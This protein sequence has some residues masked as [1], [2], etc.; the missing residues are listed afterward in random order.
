MNKQ[1]VLDSRDLCDIDL[2]LNGS[3]D[4]VNS[5]MG[6]ADYHSVLTDMR[7]TNGKVFPLPITLSTSMDIVIGET[8]TLVDK[9]NYPI[10][11]IKL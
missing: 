5:Y 6:E 1:L 3:F 7:L 10:I 11:R 4:P 8:I 9:H 2:L